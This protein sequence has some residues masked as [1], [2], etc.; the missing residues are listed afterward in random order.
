MVVEEAF[1]AKFKLKVAITIFGCLIVFVLES[2]S[3]IN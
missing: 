3:S 2:F 1:G